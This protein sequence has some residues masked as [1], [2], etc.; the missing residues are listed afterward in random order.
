MGSIDRE[1]AGKGHDLALLNS[2]ANAVD[3]LVVDLG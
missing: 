2:I 3:I 1:G